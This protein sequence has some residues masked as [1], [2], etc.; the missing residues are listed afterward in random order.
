MI[1]FSASPFSFPG[2]RV[3]RRES[4][5]GYDLSSEEL[6][7]LKAGVFLLQWTRKDYLGNFTVLT[8]VWFPA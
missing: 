8:G 3:S 2:L 7:K 5:P 1:F 6:D 4:H